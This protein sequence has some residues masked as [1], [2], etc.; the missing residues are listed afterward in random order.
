MAG[1]S[2]MSSVGLGMIPRSSNTAPT[3]HLDRLAWSKN[4]KCFLSLPSL[5]AAKSERY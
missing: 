1:T 4:G 3:F 5:V 2:N